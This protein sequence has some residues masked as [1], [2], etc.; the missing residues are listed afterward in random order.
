MATSAGEV[1]FES[2]LEEFKAAKKE[3][4]E[5]W[6]EAIGLD[7]ASTAANVAP[8]DTSRLKN[9]ISHAV[10]AKYSALTA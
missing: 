4:L 8:V 7:A 5:A 1:K 3:Q 9:S 2:H 6:L 10:E